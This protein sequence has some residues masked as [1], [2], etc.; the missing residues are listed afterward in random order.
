MPTIFQPDDYLQEVSDQHQALYQSFFA[1]SQNT[2]T[3]WTDETLMN[4]NSVI[5]GQTQ[6]NS[7][8][9]FNQPYTTLLEEFPSLKGIIVHWTHVGSTYICNPPPLDTDIDN[10]I[11]LK[12][13]DPLKLR[14]VFQILM[15][16]G[17]NG[18]EEYMSAHSS[19][20][21]SFK[22][23]NLNVIFTTS[24]LFYNDFRLAASV[25]KKLNLLD[26]EDRIM[27]HDAIISGIYPND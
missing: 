10:L 16:N 6:T 21:H 17:W 24:K 12:S 23:D 7:L 8:L 19:E 5:Q 4:N 9:K 3:Q 14:K 26:K 15:D 2:P 25:C 22:K 1:Q 13:I 18:N 27:V 20:F 11:L